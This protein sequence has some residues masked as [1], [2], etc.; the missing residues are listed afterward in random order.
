MII[1]ADSGGCDDNIVGIKLKECLHP[2]PKVQ[3]GCV[4]A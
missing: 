3:R 2:D 1:L 4:A